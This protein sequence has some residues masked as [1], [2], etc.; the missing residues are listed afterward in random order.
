MIKK[1]YV[2][3]ALIAGMMVSCDPMTES[4]PGMSANLTEA[5]LQSR[6]TVTQTVAGQNKFTFST[7]PALTVQVLDQDGAIL[8]TG[9]EGSIIGTPPLTGLT[10]RAMESGRFHRILHARRDDLR[11]RGRTL[12]LQAALRPGIHFP[13][14]GLGYRSK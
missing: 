3:M 7:N 6:V 10:V 2:A 12:Y 14:M 1:I 4:D 11:V 13:H 5:D 9:T 8:A